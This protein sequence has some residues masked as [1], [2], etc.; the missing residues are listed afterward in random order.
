MK[1]PIWA[2]CSRCN[3]ITEHKTGEGVIKQP[4]F[5]ERSTLENFISISKTKCIICG[6]KRPSKLAT[7]FKTKVRER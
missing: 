7:M 4:F 1:K 5:G 6:G 3:R 2:Y